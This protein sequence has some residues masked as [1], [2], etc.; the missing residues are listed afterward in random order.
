MLLTTPKAE[1]KNV[2]QNSHKI[3]ENGITTIDQSMV[4][5][6]DDKY[7]MKD[8]D[9]CIRTSVRFFFTAELVKTSKN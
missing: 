3:D 9:S 8:A 2:V 6:N 7:E 5:G 1:L 4:Q